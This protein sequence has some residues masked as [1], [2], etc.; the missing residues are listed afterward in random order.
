LAEE[1]NP[2]TLAVIDL[3]QENT[4]A[5]GRKSSLKKAMQ[6]L[7]IKEKVILNSF[8]IRFDSKFIRKAQC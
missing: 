8:G 3:L 4:V 5:K 2:D 6:N 7:V 1:I